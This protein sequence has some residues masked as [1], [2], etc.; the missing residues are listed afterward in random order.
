[1]MGCALWRCL[2]GIERLRHL[3]LLSWVRQTNKKLVNLREPVLQNMCEHKTLIPSICLTSLN[4]NI[5]RMSYL[6]KSSRC[7]R[8]AYGISIY[9][10]YSTSASDDL[11]L[12]SIKVKDYLLLLKNQYKN[13]LD[14]V[15]ETNLKTVRTLQPIM[16]LL[17]EVEKIQS[18]IKELESLADD[19]KQDQEML[20]MALLDIKEAQARLQTLEEKLFCSLVPDEKTGNSEVII[21]VSA[22]VGGQE[23]ML[24]CQEIFN[25]YLAYAD[26]MG[27][28]SQVTVF[29]TTD[30]GGLRHGVANIKGEAVY[31]LLKYEGGIHR[32]QRV[33]KTEKAG[34]IHTST[35]SVAVM[36]HP[37]EIDVQIFDKD[38]KI[39]TKRASG[40]GGQHV[41]TT[42]SAVR[43]THLPTGVTVESQTERSQHQNRNNCLKK[44]RFLLFQQQLDRNVNQYNSK[45]KLQVGTRARSEKIRTYNYPQDRVTDHRIGVSVHNLPAFLDGSDT[46]HSFICQLLEEGKKETLQEMID[47][48]QD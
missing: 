34:R 7:I 26:F 43:I 20:D 48:V 38:L 23:A 18:D 6:Y 47:N 39:E 21:E 32:V 12:S 25:M 11:S 42:D 40:A 2:G 22:G 41:N 9:H 24:F 1:M 44:L 29:E 17:E 14:Y 19:S 8:R 3:R 35:A 13:A 30:I 4:N 27:W 10:P 37:S 46:L 15:D 31:Q 16:Q 45:R 36:P 28:E 33:P 5:L